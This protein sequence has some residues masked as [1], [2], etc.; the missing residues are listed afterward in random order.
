MDLALEQDLGWN[1][2]FSISYM[3]SLGRELAAAVDQSVS[4]T[5][6]TATFQV[7]DNPAP[8]N[9]YITYPHGG[10]PLPLLPNSF[11]TYKKYT[12]ANGLYPN[13]YHVLDFKSE[14]NS[15][16]NALV[17][18]VNHRYSENF[19]LLTSFTWSHSLD[20]NPYLS[21]VAGSASELLDPLNPAG[22]HANSCLLY[23][24]RCV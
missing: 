16:Y 3:G 8:V 21:T 7:L 18:Q 17:F 5:T 9:G 11:H 22:E 4:P 20:N 15:S 2:V 1:T 6:S 23:T 14:V 24:S 10:R 13:Y 12:S 19:S